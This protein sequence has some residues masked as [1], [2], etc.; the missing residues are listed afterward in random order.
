M[1]Q[2][3]RRGS[4][5][6]DGGRWAV[7]EILEV[8]RAATR[9]RRVLV[10][11]RWAGEDDDGGAWE[12]S[13]VGLSLLTVDLRREAMRRLKE[14]AG[15]VTKS[16]AKVGWRRSPR[17]AAAGPS[18]AV[19][20]EEEEA[21]ASEGS[22]GHESQASE[23]RSSSE[24]SDGEEGGESTGEE[25][26]GWSGS[27]EELAGEAAAA[28]RQRWREAQEEEAPRADDEEWAGH[29]GEKRTRTGDGPST[30]VAEA[31]PIPNKPSPQEYGGG[32][33]CS[34]CESEMTVSDRCG[35]E[36]AC[37]H[38][39]CG[40]RIRRVERRAS[41]VL[42]DFDLCME[43]AGGD[44]A[45]LTR[46]PGFDEVFGCNE[47]VYAANVWIGEVR[48]AGMFAR[49]RINA[50]TILGEYTGEVMSRRRAEKSDMRDNQYLMDARR[51]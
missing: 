45:L 17:L 11:V 39:L 40:R 4:E 26:E 47:L 49:R 16:I 22:E 36:L 33:L 2:E 34:I 6:D 1:V 7:E 12:D 35:R 32:I 20:E 21:S 15:K 25:E 18:G 30:E 31:G 38:G 28:A 50:G 24:G 41:C 14:R 51:E 13:W 37:D 29:S 46:F 44:E 3:L 5:A 48:M 10:K 19:E 27:E 43:C 23:G 42:C 8:A 9:G